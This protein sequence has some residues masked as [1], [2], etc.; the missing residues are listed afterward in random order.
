VPNIFLASVVDLDHDDVPQI[1]TRTKY[2]AASLPSLLGMVAGDLASRHRLAP[3]TGLRITF[4]KK[5]RNA[6]SQEAR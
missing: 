6:L 3:D 1:V 5:E 4:R 2:E